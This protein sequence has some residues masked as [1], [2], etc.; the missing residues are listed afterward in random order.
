MKPDSDA[1]LCSEMLEYLPE[2]THALDEFVRLL[3][4]GGVVV[5]LEDEISGKLS[6]E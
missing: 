3:K 4:P 1:I 6:L 2:P 5:R